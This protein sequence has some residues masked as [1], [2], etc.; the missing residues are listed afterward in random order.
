VGRF[1]FEH[2]PEGLYELTFTLD[3]PFEAV[4]SRLSVAAGTTD[5]WVQARP[6]EVGDLVFQAS[7]A[8]TREPLASFEV[9][10]PVELGGSAR[11][12]LGRAG[13]ATV[14]DVPLAAPL[15]WTLAAPGYRPARGGWDEVERTGGEPPLRAEVELAPGWGAWLRVLDASGAQPGGVEI[16]ADGELVGETQEGEAF[17]LV[18]ETRPRTIE[19]RAGAWTAKREVLDSIYESLFDVQLELAREP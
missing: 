19:A 13:V 10:V 15:V 1:E 4:P 6:L 7:D 16:L 11:H 3:G 17:A 14:F 2:V 12:E 9:R 5:V 18:R 8:R